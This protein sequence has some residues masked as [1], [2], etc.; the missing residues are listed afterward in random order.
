MVGR[1]RRST[2]SDSFL[3]NGLEPVV[4]HH[5]CGVAVPWVKLERSTNSID[6]RIA[7]IVGVVRKTL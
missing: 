4:E 2:P 6:G 1:Y 7:P 5:Q 3:G